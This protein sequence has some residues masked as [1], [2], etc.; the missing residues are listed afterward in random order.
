MIKCLKTILISHFFFYRFLAS[1]DSYHSLA[2]S[3]RVG[4]STVSKIVKDV[5]IALW[6][7]HQETYMPFPSTAEDWKAVAATFAQ[8]NYP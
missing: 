1:G 3:F 2:A 4:V 5:C 8:W 6:N 7:N